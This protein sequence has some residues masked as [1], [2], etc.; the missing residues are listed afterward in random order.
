MMVCSVAILA[1][2]CA[3][4][5]Y[6]PKISF[7]QD[8]HPATGQVIV[9]YFYGQA[10]CAS[11]LKIEKFTKNTLG[12]QFERELDSGRVVFAPMNVDEPQNRH[13]VEDYQLYTKSVVLSLVKGGEEVRYANLEK[14]WQLLRSEERFGAYVAEEL[15]KMLKEL[16]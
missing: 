6:L 8:E 7:S 11:C 4:A 3:A 15:N 10:R 1:V 14:V 5:L 2:V 9:Y 13:F 12:S 16:S